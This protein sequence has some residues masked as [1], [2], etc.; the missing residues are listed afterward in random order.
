MKTKI[1]FLTLLLLLFVFSG[2]A[3]IVTVTVQDTVKCCPGGIYPHFPDADSLDLDADGKFD[4]LFNSTSMIDGSFFQ[5]WPMD[6]PKIAMS[7]NVALYD[8]TFK[9]WS[10][11]G[12][13]IINNSSFGCDWI[14]WLPGSGYH[15]VGYRD[16]LGPNDTI[17]GWVK[18][19]FTGPPSSCNDTLFILEYGYDTVPNTHV[20]AGVVS[21]TSV[22]EVLISNAVKVY[23]NPTS[24]T[25]YITNQS[26]AELVLNLTGLK[27]DMCIA[28]TVEKENSKQIDIHNLPD[29]IYFLNIMVGNSRQNYKII[30]SG[31]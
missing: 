17:F 4:L 10:T 29:G 15:Y 16:I 26:S 18:L 6:T 8:S 2:K 23:P 20:K 30:K 3:Q 27:G 11:Y 25:I 9:K 5:C 14:G 13:N 22:Q 1:T 31:K 19:N 28:N 24:G 12:Q 7:M 21:P